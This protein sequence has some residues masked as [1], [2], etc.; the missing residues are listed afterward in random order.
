MMT[1]LLIKKGERSKIQTKVKPKKTGHN[2]AS[3][4]SEFTSDDGTD[5]NNSSPNKRGDTSKINDYSFE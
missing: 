2:A 1:I 3:I 5:F 4:L